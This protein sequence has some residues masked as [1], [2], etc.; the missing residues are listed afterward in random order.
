MSKRLTTEE[1]IEKAKSIHGED[2]YDYS[3]VEYV[4]SISKV[5][6][7]CNK[8]Q[9]FFEQS[10][11]THNYCGCPKCG[12][13]RSLSKRTK[14]QEEF[15][16]Q[17]S[18]KH[19][20]KYDYSLVKYVNNDTY[21]DIICPEHSIFRQGASTHLSGKGCPSC[22]NINTGIKLTSST[23]TFIE[24]SK[25]KFG[26]KF[27]YSKVQYINST[28]PVIIICKEHGEF[29]QC[30]ATHLRNNIKFGCPKCNP[31][32]QS[33]TK[34]FIKKCRLKHG[35]L[36]NYDFVNYIGTKNKVDIVCPNHGIFSQ[37]AQSHLAGAI[38]PQCQ[39]NGKSTTEDFIEKAKLKHGDKYTYENVIY[40]GVNKKID[41]ICKTHGIFSTSGASHLRGSGCPICARISIHSNPNL[42][43][44]KEWKNMG[45]NSKNFES[46][47]V[48]ILK[49]WNDNEIF[50]KIGK[51]FVNISLRYKHKSRMPYN[52]EI[53][54]IYEGEGIEMS[55]FEKILQDKHK[56]YKY[57]PD[58]AF[59][60][61]YECFSK[62]I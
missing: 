9:K 14:T 34:D 8:C 2:K 62:I 4:N 37:V 11:S 20:G 54:K 10:P 51:T 3:Q 53:I 28:T 22:G 27:D 61:R 1:F 35:N 30:P 45:E 39:P 58:I 47:K 5:K 57:L 17:V 36:Y 40:D 15:I 31:I 50:Y 12:H 16:K 21:I 32:G 46:F 7:F 56:Q 33:N 24:R 52:Y 25:L 29:N 48:Y 55:K 44:H 42:F 18:E 26:D 13:E 38:C 60:G 43:K 49:C 41:I 6:I 23:E 59:G 19:Q